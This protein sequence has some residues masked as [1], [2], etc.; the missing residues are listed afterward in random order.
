MSS[1]FYS[2]IAVQAIENLEEGKNKKSE[3]QEPKRP[4]SL[5]AYL[6][7]KIS[8]GNVCSEHVLEAQQYFLFLHYYLLFN[9]SLINFFW[10]FSAWTNI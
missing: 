5:V 10:I 9:L 8:V 1:E 3:I 6:L 4:D 7:C 2:E